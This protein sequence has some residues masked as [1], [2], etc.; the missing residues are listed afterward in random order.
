MLGP[1]SSARDARPGLKPGGCRLLLCS[2]WMS[3]SLVLIYQRNTQVICSSLRLVIDYWGLSCR[4]LSS[5]LS[6]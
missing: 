6:E 3:F 5:Y 4:C 2:V 1:G